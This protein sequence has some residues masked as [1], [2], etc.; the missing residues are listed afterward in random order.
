MLRELLAALREPMNFFQWLM[1]FVVLALVTAFVIGFVWVIVYG[2]WIIL[3][4]AFS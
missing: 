2:V 1:A 4:R 3:S